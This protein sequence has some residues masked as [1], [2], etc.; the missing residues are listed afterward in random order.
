MTYEN[1][2][3]IMYW[4]VEKLDYLTMICEK[5]ILIIMYWVAEKCVKTYNSCCRMIKIRLLK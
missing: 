3:N 2:L 5:K 1:I 4:I